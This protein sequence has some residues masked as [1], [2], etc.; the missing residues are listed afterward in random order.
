MQWERRQCG[1]PS[2]SKQQSP[3][4]SPHLRVRVD[5]VE[6]GPVCGVPEL[7]AAVGRAAPEARRLLW[8][9]HH[10]SAL[11]AAWCWSRR[12]RYCTEQGKEEG[13]RAE[14]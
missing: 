3:S 1:V 12:C 5:G 11:T 8:K 6:A 7:D 4:F 2:S 14:G 13:D 10:A 9:G